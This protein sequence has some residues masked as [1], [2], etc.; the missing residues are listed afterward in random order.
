LPHTPDIH[1]GQEESSKEG[2]Q[3]QN[4]YNRG[5]GYTENPKARENE[6]P[7][8]ELNE[9]QIK[10]LLQDVKAQ[11][12][13]R[14]K[15]NLLMICKSDTNNRIYGPPGPGL[16][17]AFQIRWDYIKSMPIERYM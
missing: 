9:F 10:Q 8:I 7:K 14:D 15:V 4:L 12:L 3:S 1:H 6:T 16:H 11:K 5:Y 2:Y 17:C 13:I